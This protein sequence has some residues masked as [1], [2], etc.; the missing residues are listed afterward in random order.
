MVK[1]M[2]DKVNYVIADTKEELATYLTA[3]LPETRQSIFTSMGKSIQL[4]SAD[5]ARKLIAAGISRG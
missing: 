2:S 3:N 5:D 1:L 4:V